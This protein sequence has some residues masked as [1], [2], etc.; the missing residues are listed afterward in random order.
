M[1]GATGPLRSNLGRLERSRLFPPEVIVRRPVPTS[2]VHGKTLFSMLQLRN[3]ARSFGSIFDLEGSHRISRETVGTRT[4]SWLLSSKAS[5]ATIENKCRGMDHGAS[6]L[7]GR[8]HI[9][10]QRSRSRTGP[11]YH[12]RGDECFRIG[13]PILLKRPDGSCLEWTIGGIERISTS[14]PRPEHHVAILLKGLDR[15]DLPVGSEIWS[16]DV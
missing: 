8:R 6:A 13:D 16:T 15:D 12:S 4:K 1:T 5:G 3:V 2:H 7:R 14:T 10:D 11:G 9:H